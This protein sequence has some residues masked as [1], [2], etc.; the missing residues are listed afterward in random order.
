MSDTDMGIG[1]KIFKR[2]L[3]TQRRSFCQEEKVFLKRRKQDME[4]LTKKMT[5]SVQQAIDLHFGAEEQREVNSSFREEC[6]EKGS[7]VRGKAHFLFTLCTDQLT[8][9]NAFYI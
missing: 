5:P 4:S 6:D 7:A 1:A 2:N 8:S 9:V 3:A